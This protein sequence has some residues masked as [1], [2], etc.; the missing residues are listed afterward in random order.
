MDYYIQVH[1]VKKY[2]K[3]EGE[4]TKELNLVFDEFRK[5]STSGVLIIFKDENN[6]KYKMFLQDLIRAIKYLRNGHLVGKF[7]TVKRGYY[8]GIKL[9]EPSTKYPIVSDLVAIDKNRIGVRLIEPDNSESIIPFLK[10]NSI[11]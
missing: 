2:K 8:I 7:T 10:I 4:I 3:F 1:H 5:S 9:V 6:I 11:C